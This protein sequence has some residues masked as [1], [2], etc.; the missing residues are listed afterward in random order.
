MR[1]APKPTEFQSFRSYTL[2]VCGT[3]TLLR[4][5][6]RGSGR[7]AKRVTQM[8]SSPRPR[9]LAQSMTF[10]HF[11]A[12]THLYYVTAT[13]L[14]WRPL[15]VRSQFAELVLNSLDWHRQHTHWGLYAFV[16][17]P[18]HAHFIIKPV[19]G[20]TISSNLQSFASF[21]AHA[22]IEQLQADNLTDDLRFFAENRQPDQSEKHQIWQ[23]LQAKNVISPEFL[24]EKLGYIHNNPAA[25]KWRLAATRADYKYSSAC[26]YDRGQPAVI[27][28]DDVREWLR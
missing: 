1:R 28:V 4:A 7:G 14:G 12:D 20:F 19:Q 25:K 5:H 3:R 9:G 27:P 23:P 24:R 2:R 22:I 26:Y 18:T 10:K 15:F 13:L 8:L 11:H 6:L 17:M 16:V 21:T